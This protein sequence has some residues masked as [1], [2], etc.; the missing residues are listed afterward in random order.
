MVKTFGLLPAHQSHA[1]KTAMGHSKLLYGALFDRHALWDPVTIDRVLSSF[2]KGYVEESDLFLI[3]AECIA[4]SVL[5]GQ[6]EA[7]GFHA[8][9]RGGLLLLSFF[10]IP[11]M[12]TRVG[13]VLGMARSGKIRECTTELPG[14][15]GFPILLKLVKRITISN[16]SSRLQLWVRKIAED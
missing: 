10:Q 15:L 5:H 2:P 4:N 14:G 12:Q 8:R 3:L 16:D 7:L 1:F 9:E 6:A 11:P 13:L